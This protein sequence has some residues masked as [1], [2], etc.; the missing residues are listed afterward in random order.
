[1]VAKGIV[2]EMADSKKCCYGTDIVSFPKDR[3]LEEVTMSTKQAEYHIFAA[4][5]D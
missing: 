2:G 4:D 5:C 3:C 1:M